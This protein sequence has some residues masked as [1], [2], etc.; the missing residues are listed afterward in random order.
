MLLMIII[1]NIEDTL[2]GDLEHDA[3]LREFL[4][5]LTVT[6]LLRRADGKYFSVGCVGRSYAGNSLFTPYLA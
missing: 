3:A 5:K 6:Q 1:L 2:G 4:Q